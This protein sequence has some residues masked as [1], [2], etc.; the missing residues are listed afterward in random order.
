MPTSRTITIIG[1]L[2]RLTLHPGGANTSVLGPRGVGVQ[3]VVYAVEAHESGAQRDDGP[4]GQDDEA[5]A[6]ELHRS[7][8][9][10]GCCFE[11]RKVHDGFSLV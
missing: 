3:N 1:K 6:L 11:E 10:V 5:R 9:V 7:I 8:V 4:D 2:A